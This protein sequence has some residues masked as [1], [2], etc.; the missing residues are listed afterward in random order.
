MKSEAGDLK[1]QY[2]AQVITYRGIREKGSGDIVVSAVCVQRDR[3]ISIYI[4]C[5]SVAHSW[6]DIFKT[7][8]ANSAVAGTLYSN[9]IAALFIIKKNRGYRIKTV[10]LI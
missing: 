6:D 9:S 4:K 10:H 7:L 3:L 5:N 8:F 1:A 2:A